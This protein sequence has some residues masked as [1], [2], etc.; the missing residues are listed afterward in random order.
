LKVDLSAA[1]ASIM[2]VSTVYNQVVEK[3]KTKLLCCT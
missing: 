2:S 1:K 3:T